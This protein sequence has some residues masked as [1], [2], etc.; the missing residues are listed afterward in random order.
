MSTAE[1]QTQDTVEC[2]LCAAMLPLDGPGNLAQHLAQDH[3]VEFEGLFVPKPNDVVVLKTAAR[4]LSDA[5]ARIFWLL[6]Q[7]DDTDY[8]YVARLQLFA[9]AHDLELAAHAL[10]RSR[11]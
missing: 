3:G 7:P 5:G 6:D 8:T 10:R 11:Q 2:G 4:V 1:T 9:A